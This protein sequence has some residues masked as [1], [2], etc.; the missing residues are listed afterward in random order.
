MSEIALVVGEER[1]V[2]AAVDDRPGRVERAL[3]VGGLQRERVVDDER[4]PGGVMR[5]RGERSGRADE[6][7][8]RDQRHESRAICAR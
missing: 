1:V 3:R 5:G 2:D 8:Q 7:G 6:R 4:R